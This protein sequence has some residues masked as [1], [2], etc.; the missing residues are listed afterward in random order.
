M[1]LCFDFQTAGKIIFGSGSLGRLSDIAPKQGRRFLLVTGAGSLRK[2]G[3]IGRIEKQLSEEGLFFCHYEG[4]TQEPTPTIV[5]EGCRIARENKCDAILA[6]GG[7]S[8]ID[9]GKAIS[10]L[11][12]NDGNL[13]DYLEGVGLGKKLV[14]KPA[15]F[16]AIPTTSGTGSEVT[17]NAVISSVK[18]NFKKSFR[19]DNLVPDVAIVDPLLTLTLPKLQTAASA[20]DALTQLIEVYV[21]KEPKPI[22]DKLALYGISQCMNSIEEVYNDGCNLEARERVAL[23]SLL[24]GICLANSRLGA[25]HGIAAGI[26]AHYY[27]PHGVACAVLLPHIIELNLESRINRYAEVSRT[28]IKTEHSLNE[29]AAF[30]LIDYIKNLQN[31]FGL[32]DFKNYNIA[33]KDLNKIAASSRGNSMRGNPIYLDDKTI[34][35]VLTKLI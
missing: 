16:I 22:T 27:V 19:D 2:N 9:T 8:V 33:V 11:I 23:A 6:I 30:D 4:V 21:T 14:K 25:V 28:L 15:P 17:K 24:S 12:T 1:T 20:M 35:K 32:T 29:I 5:D 31:M 10:G 34:I 26:G 18:D 7:G 3:V 13:I